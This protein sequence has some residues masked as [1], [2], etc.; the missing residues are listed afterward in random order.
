MPT[1]KNA[2]LFL[3]SLLMKRTSANKGLMH[4]ARNIPRHA[5]HEKS[6]QRQLADST[7]VSSQE[8]KAFLVPLINRGASVDKLFMERSLTGCQPRVSFLN[9]IK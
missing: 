5:L 2:F 7:L 9:R 1:K 6:L 8:E 4:H 3:L